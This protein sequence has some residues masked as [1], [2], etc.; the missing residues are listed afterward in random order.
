MTWV[1]HGPSHVAAGSGGVV[2]GGGG[3]CGEGRGLDGQSVEQGPAQPTWHQY[4]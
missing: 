1:D 4:H 3:G 2:V